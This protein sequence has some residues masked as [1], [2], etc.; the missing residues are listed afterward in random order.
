MRR[1]GRAL[2]PLESARIRVRR[3]GGNEGR[4]SGE[5]V[6]GNRSL[7]MQRERQ[8]Q[9]VGSSVVAGGK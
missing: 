3:S 9:S 1:D 6:V 7:P 5:N 4:D 2:L 8:D